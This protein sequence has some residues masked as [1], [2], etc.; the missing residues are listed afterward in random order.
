MADDAVP[1]IPQPLKG[2]RVMELAHWM[3]G[4]A[5]GGILADWGAE[6][7]K[8][9][10]PGGEPMRNIWS[11]MGA[12]PDAP[13]A[14]FISANRG[15]QSIELDMRSDAGRDTLHQLLND[16]DVLLTNLRPGALERLGLSPAD[17]AQR[18]PRLIYCS[19]TAYGWG[20]PDQDKAGYDLASFFG[21]T[22]IAHE[23][24]T[25]GTAPAP[26]MQGLGDTFTAMTAVA[27][28][29]AAVIE[30]QH[31]GQGRMVEA[32]LMRTGMWALA[33]EL[34][35]Q[36]MGGHPRPPKP[37]AECSTPL[38]NS[39]ATKDERWFYL[40]GVEAG[41]HLPRVLAAIGRSDLLE[42]ERFSSARA[43][44]KNRAEFIPILDAA[45]AT[46]TL[47]EWDV[48]FDEHDVF[49]GPVQTPADVVADPQARATGAWIRIEEVDVESVDSPIRFDGVI[50]TSAA[51][52]PRSGEQTEQI[53]ARLGSRSVAE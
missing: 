31:T 6:V 48:I 35:V 22:G 41:R 11:S 30:R 1:G 14:A 36:A 32:S 21:R 38:Y 47:A 44:A 4:P 15:K 45:F 9:E 33:G 53:L 49:W 42:D 24:T 43:V 13:N 8:V 39:Y 25:R 10:P 2:I 50:R 28:I 16:A 26:L 7:I 29:L 12:N 34:G 17:V 46:R 5:A 37:R 40:V 27:G 23:I 51:R 18:H 19:L 3:A 20:G 52:P